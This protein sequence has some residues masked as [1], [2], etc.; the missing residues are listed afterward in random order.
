[1]TDRPGSPSS[2][3]TR[4]DSYT[5]RLLAGERA[6]WRRLFDVQAPYRWNLRRLE[7]GFTLDV[8]CGIGRNLL[9]FEGRGVGIDHN[10]ASVDVARSRGL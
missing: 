1:M 10:P 9:H 2:P 7:L 4:D 8:G 3:S 6:W 5:S